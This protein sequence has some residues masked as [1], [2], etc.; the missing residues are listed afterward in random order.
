MPNLSIEGQLTHLKLEAQY[1][2]SM[3]KYAAALTQQAREEAAAELRDAMARLAVLEKSGS[4]DTMDAATLGEYFAALLER[5]ALTATVTPEQARATPGWETG[6]AI[7][8]DGTNEA[9]AEAVQSLLNDGYA[10]YLKGHLQVVRTELDQA[11]LKK[12]NIKFSVFVQVNMPGG[13]SIAKL[14]WHRLN[15]PPELI[16]SLTE[17]QDKVKQDYYRLAAL[18]MIA[19]LKEAYQ[20]W[21]DD[22]TPVNASR[23]AAAQEVV[24]RYVGG[25]P[26]HLVFSQD[27]ESLARLRVQ[28][29]EGSLGNRME[30]LNQEIQINEQ[31]RAQVLAGKRDFTVAL[32][33]VTGNPLEAVPSLVYA[34]AITLTNVFGLLHQPKAPKPENAAKPDKKKADKTPPINA[35][36]ERLK[37]QKAEM[38]RL[39]ADLLRTQLQG[40]LMLNDGSERLLEVSPGRYVAVRELH[41]A[42]DGQTKTFFVV[43]T[44]PTKIPDSRK[45]DLTL[46]DANE[47]QKRN[48][49][50]GTVAAYGTTVVYA[51]DRVTLPDGQESLQIV[52]FNA[53]TLD[54]NKVYEVAG[55]VN[56]V[57]FRAERNQQAQRVIGEVMEKFLV[58][59]YQVQTNTNLSGIS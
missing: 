17:N 36:D 51:A 44:L 46:R 42:V 22:P 58:G 16:K 47:S 45:L 53:V 2:A 9:E 18:A 31:M 1:R 49:L 40:K 39:R 38:E 15:A 55:P 4:P 7:K 43:R 5:T 32:P 52:E 50:A 27:P 30:V 34:G 24:K 25:A 21:K 35:L 6:D 48:L 56:A 3:Q 10:R 19:S 29:T 11:E 59:R 12:N 26:V 14:V 33:L 23:L 54:V 8:A 20:T 41:L 28:Q 37:A 13:P 57:L